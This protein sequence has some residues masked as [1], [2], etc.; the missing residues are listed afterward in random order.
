MSADPDGSNHELFLTE[1]PKNFPS[2]GTASGTRSEPG[3]PE[4]TPMAALAVLM[5]RPLA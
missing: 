4:V 2:A 5:I 3:K 1:L